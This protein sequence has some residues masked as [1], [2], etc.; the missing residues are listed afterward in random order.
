MNGDCFDSTAAAVG[1]CVGWNMWV[2]EDWKKPSDGRSPVACRGGWYSRVPPRTPPLSITHTLWVTHLAVE[3]GR[4]LNATIAM[5]PW[6]GISPTPSVLHHN[7]I[8]Y[9]R[10]LSSPNSIYLGTCWP[11]LIPHT[12]NYMY[13]S[14]PN[15]PK[16]LER[17]CIYVWFGKVPEQLPTEGCAV[18]LQ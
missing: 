14:F 12:P 10:R 11:I 2:R 6:R 9:A 15:W 1:C 8:I 7:I 16:W 5:G 3:G 17:V 13:S 18:G 4:W